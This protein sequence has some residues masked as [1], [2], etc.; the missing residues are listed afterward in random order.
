MLISPCNTMPNNTR[1][2]CPMQTSHK[3]LVVLRQHGLHHNY[4]TAS[5]QDEEM[6]RNSVPCFFSLAKARGINVVH[7]LRHGLRSAVQL[8][9][10]ISLWRK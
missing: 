7:L 5:G 1:L 6:D 3:M 8:L 2:L 10:I 4:G 9:E